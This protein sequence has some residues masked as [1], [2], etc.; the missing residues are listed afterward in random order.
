[1]SYLPARWHDANDWIRIAA[2]VLNPLLQ[3]KIN[4]LTKTAAYTVEEDDDLVL[5]NATGAAFT[6]TLPSAVSFEGRQFMVKKIDASA[7][8]VTV[9][10]NGAET[11]DGA[12][13][14][15]LA[16]QWAKVHLVSDGANWQTV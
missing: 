13:T 4:V 7:N 11:I 2:N 3:R 10:G 5:C 9:D 1:M 8:A 15:S 12:A 14:L 6:V 16:T